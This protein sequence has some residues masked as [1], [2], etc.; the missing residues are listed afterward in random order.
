MK[1]KLKNLKDFFSRHLPSFCQ[2]RQFPSI[3]TKK[4]KIIF[5]SLLTCL[6]SSSLFL[7]INF[8]FQHTEPVPKIWGKHIEGVMGQPRFINPILANSDVDRDLVE[9]LFSGVMKYDENGQIVPDLAESHEIKENGRV[10]EISLKSNAF[11]HDGVKITADDVIF[12]VKT[13]QDPAFNSPEIANWIGIEVEKI[14]DYKLKFILTNP[15]FPFLERLTLKIL[16]KHIFEEISAENFSL[17]IRNLE[18]IGSGPF[19]FK[20]IKYDRTGNIISL[21]L[22]RNNNYHGKTAFLQEIDFRFFQTEEQLTEAAQRNEIRGL[23]ISDPNYLLSFENATFVKYQTLFPRYFA[24]F[25]NPKKTELLADK[26]VRMALN[27]LT[28]KSAILQKAVFGQGKIIHSPILSEIYGFEMPDKVYIFNQEQAR[29]LLEKAGIEKRDGRFVKIKKN[30]VVEIKTDLKYGDRGKE[31]ENL[32]RCLSYLPDIYSDGEVSGYF[33]KAT[34]RAVINFQEKYK[35]EI[36]IPAGLEKGNGVVKLKTREK[37]NALCQKEEIVPLKFTLTTVNQPL[38]MGVAN[39]LKN[40]WQ[41]F[42]IELEIQSLPFSSLNRDIIRPREYEIL[43]FGEALGVIPDPFP[44]WHSSRI[45]DPGINLALF[46]NK[47]VDDCLKK[48]REAQSFEEMKRNLGVLQN[49]LIEEAPA[50]FLFSPDFHYFLSKEIK[51][52]NQTRIQM[53]S[54]RFAGIENWYIKTTRVWK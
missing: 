2:W 50:I 34:E 16:P 35:E 49:I 24:L 31:V 3:L 7:S 29:I 44:F 45:E 23:T 39:E 33:G 22:K 14:S 20:E 37:L 4:E 13:I 47:K 12:T 51:G 53:P 25:F 28:D 36:L 10:Y 19:L 46:E 17:N 30:Q 1:E 15:Y 43:L 38:L 9:I 52:F 8:C 6:I 18:P 48:A 5:F 11:W 54:N 21:I 32:Q 40:Q 42:G 41:E 26:N 27:Y